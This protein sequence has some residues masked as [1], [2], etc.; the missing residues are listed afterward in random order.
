MMFLAA[1]E[2]QI[3]KLMRQCQ[4]GT[5]RADLIRGL[6]LAEHHVL[7]QHALDRWKRIEQR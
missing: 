2:Y 1:Y 6:T 7:G 3:T 4:A 5:F